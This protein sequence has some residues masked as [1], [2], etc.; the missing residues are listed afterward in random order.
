MMAILILIAFAMG[1]ASFNQDRGELLNISK[2]QLV[3]DKGAEVAVID[4]SGIR[5]SNKNSRLVADS[6]VGRSNV[7]A[8]LHPENNQQ[9]A[10]LG[11]DNSGRKCYWKL[12][13]SGTNTHMV[14]SDN[15][16]AE[17]NF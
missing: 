3:D 10:E 6:I 15:G 8:N 12:E 14:L 16:T 17:S 11:I 7:R 4:A 1:A 9:Y 5:Y 13:S 2:I